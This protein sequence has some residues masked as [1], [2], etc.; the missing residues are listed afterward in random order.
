[1]K[2]LKN[3]F[4]LTIIII[5]ISSC[6]IGS[7]TNNSMDQQNFALQSSGGDVFN[8]SGTASGCRT[9]S[10]NGTCSVNIKYNGA[11]IYA[12]P[13]SISGITGYTSSIETCSSAISTIVQCS[14]TISNT[15]SASV[16]ESQGAN[17]LLNGNQTESSSIPTFIVGGGI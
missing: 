1:M 17:F 2:K 12:G 10:A 11:G 9:I 3:A 16:S 6:A 14:F 15:N 4:G 7:N 8:I 13:I 5:L